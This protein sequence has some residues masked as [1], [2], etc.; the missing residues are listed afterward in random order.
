MKIVTGC[1]AAYLPGAKALLNSIRRH[2]VDDRFE[3]W[4][5]AYGDVDL[6]KALE[7]HG[8]KVIL[9]PPYPDGVNLMSGG[10]WKPEQMPVMYARL[11]LPKIFSGD[12]RIMW[13]DADMIVK[14]SLA[15]ALDMDLAG[16]PVAGVLGE[17]CI[18]RHWYPPVV[19]KRKRHGTGCLIIDVRRW[20][21]L[22]VTERCFDAMANPPHPGSVPKGVVETIL[23][24]V[25]NGDWHPL[26][27]SWD[28]NPK[29]ADPPSGTKIYHFGCVMPWTE[30]GPQG[31]S[32]KPPSFRTQARKH[33][34]P[35]R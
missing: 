15:E 19:D 34:E 24:H 10:W 11:L 7:D 28:Q 29:R 12:D 13:L 32:A 25:L 1:D 8:Y 4:C 3:Y 18:G 6:A 26:D 5:I 35:Y 23:N 14:E 30:D 33:W 9:N 31:L 16:H 20:N 17:D 22:R 27:P 2:F 21:E